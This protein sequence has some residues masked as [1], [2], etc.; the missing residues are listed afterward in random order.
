MSKSQLRKEISELAQVLA[1]AVV[2]AISSRSLSEL[3]DI[4]E[5]RAP[6]RPRRAAVPAPTPKRV[7]R[8]AA[9]APAKK[10]AASNPPKERV[11]PEEARTQVLA[12]LKESKEWMKASAILDAM[13]K[14]CTTELLGRVL[15]ELITEGHVVKQGAT[16]NTEYQIT[17]SGLAL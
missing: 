14:P 17:A 6:T 2:K 10:A 11:S 8:K 3:A 9:S 1:D 7:A 15:R 12:V 4:T 13:K 5:N 16:R